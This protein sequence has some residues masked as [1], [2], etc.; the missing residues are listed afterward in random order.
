MR[1]ASEWLY[2]HDPPPARRAQV[3]EQLAARGWLPDLILCSDSTRT[4]Q[5]LQ[6][7]RVRERVTFTLCFQHSVKFWVAM[8]PS[9]H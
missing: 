4:K 3:A 7:M 5:T 8:S 2:S 1:R 9:R 6:S